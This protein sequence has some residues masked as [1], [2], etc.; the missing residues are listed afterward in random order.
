MDK[1]LADDFMEN[2][3]G[4]GIAPPPTRY[5]IND[6]VDFWNERGFWDYGTIRTMYYVATEKSWV[7][8]IETGE[9]YGHNVLEK[10]IRGYKK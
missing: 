9:I 10:D 7:Y 6:Y 4:G 8:Y 1:R 5:E 2:V 3:S